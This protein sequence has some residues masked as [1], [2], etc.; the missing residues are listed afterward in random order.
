MN[1][2]TLKSGGYEYVA[3]VRPGEHILEN[4]GGYEIWFCNKNHASYGLF[5]H[6]THLEFARNATHAD[7]VAARTRQVKLG[8][9]KKNKH[10]WK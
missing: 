1:K 5:F 8:K 9:I 2:E 3:M 6:N 7:F 4:D 10:I